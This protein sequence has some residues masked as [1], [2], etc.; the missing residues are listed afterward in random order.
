MLW[1][2]GCAQ[3]LKRLDG[4]EQI[5]L[6]IPIPEPEK[7]FDK[8]EDD[9]KKPAADGDQSKDDSSSKAEDTGNELDGILA[10]LDDEPMPLDPEP[11]DPVGGYCMDFKP[12]GPDSKP[13]QVH[14]QRCLTMTS[15]SG[16]SCY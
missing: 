9:G 10:L 2:G 12:P 1:T 7:K 15:T 13:G 16:Y 6:D 5:S 8:R 4:L 11:D 14:G 3:D